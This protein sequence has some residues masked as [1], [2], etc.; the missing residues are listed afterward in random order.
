M[1]KIIHI[2]LANIADYNLDYER[3]FYDNR[4]LLT[5]AGIAYPWL[6]TDRLG[7]AWQK[8]AIPHM[9]A[10][11]SGDKEEIK[12]LASSLSGKSGLLFASPFGRIALNSGTLLKFLDENPAFPEW[13]NANV[14]LVWLAPEYSSEIEGSIRHWLPT[15]MSVESK[16]AILKNMPRLLGGLEAI[17]TRANACH[18]LPDTGSRHIPA[19]TILEKLDI[20]LPTDSLTALRETEPMERDCLWLNGICRN[21][22]GDNFIPMSD[23]SKCGYDQATFLSPDDIK[24]FHQTFTPA[25]ER[26]AAKKGIKI[27]F[28]EPAPQP[29]W[30]PFL[31]VSGKKLQKN[32]ESLLLS[33]PSEKRDYL[34]RTI[35]RAIGNNWDIENIDNYIDGLRSKLGMAAAVKPLLTVL[36]LTRNHEKYITDC[37]ES[38]LA[39]KTDFP[40]RHVI[41]DHNS[42]DCTREIIRQYALKNPSIWPV[43][44]RRDS[45]GNNV[46]ELFSHCSSPYVA[47]CDGDDYF[48]DPLK[49]Q[50]QV[51]YLENNPDCALCSHYVQVKFENGASKNF[52]YPLELPKRRNMKF[53]LLDLMRSNFIQTNSV[54]YRWRFR[55]GLP[56]WFIPNLFPGDWYWHLLHAEKGKIGFIPKVMSVYRRHSNALYSSAFVNKERH[57][58]V[59]GLNELRTFDA[60]NRHFEGRYFTELAKLANGVFSSFCQ[61]GIKSGNMGKLDEACSSY[62]EFGAYFLKCL[63]DLQKQG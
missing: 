3:F 6:E 35:P 36:T 19:A 45:P 58:E 39:Q 9:E 28:P 12:N 49:L 57:F 13:T 56:D 1:K 18:I 22:P 8:A 2:L 4:D 63:Q 51:D 29:D 61:A 23:T 47:L 21:L 11:L 50:I 7:F 32:F 48:T 15:I 5:Q 43:F 44:I 25:M 46:R 54:V 14:N 30:T 59:N 38:V 42:T 17:L 62:P 10:I 31:P 37:I 26:V 52:N 20:H 34:L 27:E 60:V 55:D 16:T 53:Y 24:I 33:A 41:V 40:V